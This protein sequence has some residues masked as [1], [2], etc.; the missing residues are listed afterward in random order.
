MK[1]V[2]SRHRVLLLLERELVKLEKAAWKRVARPHSSMLPFSQT[3]AGGEGQRRA[4]L[5]LSSHDTGGG[6]RGR[7]RGRPAETLTLPLNSGPPEW[8]D[9]ELV[10]LFVKSCP[11]SP[12]LVK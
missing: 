11:T 7:L 9:S 10:N 3:L 5:C 4:L 12:V 2:S 1:N 6:H 8:S